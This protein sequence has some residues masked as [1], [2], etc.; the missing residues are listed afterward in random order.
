MR[1]NE[2]IK[3][4]FEAK[5]LRETTHRELRR[6][7]TLLE[8]SFNQQI[9]PGNDYIPVPIYIMHDHMDTFKRNKL[10]PKGEFCRLIKIN[11]D[12]FEFK[13]KAGEL[14]E[15]PNQKHAGLSYMTTLIAHDVTSYNKIRTMLALIFNLNL[16]PSSEE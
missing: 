6:Q 16:P 10:A 5:R 11:P 3:E 1:V 8:K 2:I 14:I 7:I 9:E 15:W 4:S 13:D 12:T